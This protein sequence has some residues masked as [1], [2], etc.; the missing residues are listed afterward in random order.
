[1]RASDIVLTAIKDGRDSE[2]RWISFGKQ[3][4]HSGHPACGA[5]SICISLQRWE[6]Q[7]FYERTSKPQW[8]SSILPL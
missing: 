1:L 4:F 7:T 2:A 3:T 8:Y 6:V 5:A